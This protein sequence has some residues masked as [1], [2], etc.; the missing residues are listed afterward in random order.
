MKHE[1]VATRVG[2]TPLTMLGPYKGATLWI[3]E[4]GCNP[5]GSL[6]D[7]TAFGILCELDRKGELVKTRRVLDASSGSFA[8]A[9]AYYA[10]LFELETTVVVNSK[11][12]EDNL[13]F[14][15]IMG[16]EVIRY[17]HVTGESRQRCLEM[18]EAEPTAY[19]FTDQLENGIA[20]DVH[21]RT[22]A[23]EIFL[24]GLPMVAAV[25]GSVGSG[26]TMLGVGRYVRMQHP[27]TRVFASIATLGDDKKIAGT[28]LEGVDYE[29]PFIKS[30][31]DEDLLEEIPILHEAAMR[32][33]VE[34]ARQGILIGPQGGGVLEAACLAVDKHGIRGNVV[35]IAGDTLLKNVS[36]F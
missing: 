14:L 18:L 6:K 31:R 22:T 24:Q 15:D 32:R 23:P 1:T 8:C 5:T 29:S 7:R 13:K 21:Q 26:A 11:I 4:E 28:Y 36:R 17:G 27:G 20:P 34:T 35:L 25:V 10:R 30:L 19:I 3:K 2:N 33:V 9:L 12:S 16:A